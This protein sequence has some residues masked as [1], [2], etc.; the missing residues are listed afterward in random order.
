MWRG[1]VRRR[2]RLVHLRPDVRAYCEA[3]RISTTTVSW[4]S[5]IEFSWPRI[6][7]LRSEKYTDTWDVWKKEKYLSGIHGAP[8]TRALKIK[9][10]LAFQRP[11]DIHIWGY[12]ADKTDVVRAEADAV[13]LP[14]YGGGVPADREGADQGE[15][16][17]T[18]R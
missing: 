4:L 12:T 11:D 9:P 2:A 1:F 6:T 3:P 18:A 8:C 5:A 14:R 17:G 13:A 15:L 10:R 16:P 7:I